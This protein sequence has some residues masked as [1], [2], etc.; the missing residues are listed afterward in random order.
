MTNMALE[1]RA[2]LH[3]KNADQ[4]TKQVALHKLKLLSEGTDERERERARIALAEID[5]RV[6]ITEGVQ[7]LIRDLLQVTGA[8][9]LSQVCEF[10]IDQFLESRGFGKTG[11][12]K[13]LKRLWRAAAR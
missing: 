6:R 7:Q 9:M 5:A 2:I 3:S 12:P 4:Y 8:N 10:E 13:R 11:D 1:L